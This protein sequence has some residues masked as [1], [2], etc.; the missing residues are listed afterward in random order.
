MSLTF[1]SKGNNHTNQVTD[2][3]LCTPCIK[4]HNA[5]E[6]HNPFHEFFEIREPG[7]VIVHTV[8]E[9]DRRRGE[10]HSNA[11]QAAAASAPAPELAIMHNARCDLCDTAIIGTRY[12]CGECP[13]F[14]TCANC[15]QITTE[16][17]PKHS[18]FKL[19]KIDD[20]IVRLRFSRFYLYTLKIYF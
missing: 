12:K 1:V 7:R 8:F 18:F 9:G 19:E 15:F 4:E 10:F 11:T 3:D 17:H 2:Y 20:Y 5:A 13:D 14:D 16:Q 6:K